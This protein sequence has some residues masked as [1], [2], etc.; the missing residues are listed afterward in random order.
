MIEQEG[1]ICFYLRFAYQTLLN[2]ENLLKVLKKKKPKM[3]DKSPVLL[4]ERRKGTR[5][6]LGTEVIRG[7]RAKS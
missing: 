5:Y 7:T 6:V 1:K 4:V 3:I 2:S